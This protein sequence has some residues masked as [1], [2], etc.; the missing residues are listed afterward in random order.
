MPAEKVADRLAAETDPNKVY[1][2]YEYF[3]PKTEQG[4]TNLM[5]RAKR[6]AVEGPEFIDFTWGAGGTT[7]DLTTV[8]CQRVQEFGAN[9]NMHLTCT[10]MPTG[11][12]DEAIKFCKE[13]D[14]VN[15]VTLRGDPPAGQEWKACEEGFTCALDLMKY[16]NKHHPGEFSMSV[17]GYPEAHPDKIDAGGVVSEKGYKDDL[18]YLKL[19]C[20]E[21]AACVITQLFYDVSLFIKFVKDCKDIGITCP[22]LPG[23]LPINSYGGFHK[24]VSFCK[25]KVPE[26]VTRR[27]EE[28]KDSPDELKK[29]GVDQAVGMC[30]QIMQSEV[31]SKH[32]HFYTLNQD[33]QT[34]DILEKLGVPLLRPAEE[35]E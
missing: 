16:I 29:F 32:I 34:L 28:L 10:N 22:I 18:A 9:A 35:K 13:H 11:K 12:V 15:L 14:I 23:I 33:A 1:F 25:V 24:I 6:M 19:K 26:D 5:R 17:A 8:L 2:S 7:S 3:P 4:V 30:Q 27:V 21:G 31:C 20:D